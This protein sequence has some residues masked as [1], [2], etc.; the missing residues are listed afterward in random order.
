MKTWEDAYFSYLGTYVPT[1]LNIKPSDDVD[2]DTDGACCHKLAA[3][4]PT[5]RT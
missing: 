5:I 3:L 1:W 2:V 4:S